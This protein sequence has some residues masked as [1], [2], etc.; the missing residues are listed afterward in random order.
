MSRYAIIM[1]HIRDWQKCLWDVKEE[2]PTVHS[3]P[4]LVGWP[5]D[6]PRG[7]GG[8]APKVILTKDIKDYLDTMRFQSCLIDLPIGDTTIKRLRRELG[9]N[10][11]KDRPI[12]WEKRKEDLRTM[13]LEKF[14][15]KHGCSS[16]AASQARKKLI[17]K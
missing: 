15:E 9:H 5:T 10:W 2:R 17:K 7:P 1:Y 11:Y 8:G 3:W 14:F 16:G 6:I 13:T 4:F 12:W